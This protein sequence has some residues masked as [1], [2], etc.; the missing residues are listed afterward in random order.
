MVWELGLFGAAESR[1][2]AGADADLAAAREQGLRVSVVAAVV[3]LSDLGVAN[4][5]IALL[6]QMAELDRE[7]E[8]L[9]QVRLNTRLGTPQD[10]DTASVRRQRTWPRW[11]RC[12]WRPTGRRARWRCCWAAT[13]RIPAGARWRRRRA[14]PVS[15]WGSAG[16]PAAHPSGHPRGRSRSASGRRKAGHGA[17]GA[18]SAPEP[19]WFGPVR[20]QH[21]AEPPLEQQLRS[22]RRAHDRYPALGLGRPPGAGQGRRAGHRRG[23]GRLPQG[24]VVR[25][26]GSRG[27][28]VRAGSR[29]RAHRRAGRGAEG[30]G[31]AQRLAA[32]AGVAGLSSPYDGL[33]GR[34]ALLE[35]QSDVALRARADPGLRRALQGAGRRRW[36]RSLSRHSRRNSRRNNRRNNRRNSWRNNPGRCVHDRPGAQDPGL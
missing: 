1:L 27:I 35:A 25:R 8:R 3:Q 23:A 26:V 11:R 29:T 19:G 20:V 15:P 18:V 22:G 16:R 13:R 14:C 36:R 10:A 33:E 32:Q 9:A 30:A 2:Q 17:L 5:Q 21:D 7:A 34:R 4:G 6:T 24:G 28:A 12:A 31:P